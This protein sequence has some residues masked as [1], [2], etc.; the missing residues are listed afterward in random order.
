MGGRISSLMPVIFL[1]LKKQMGLVNQISPAP[2]CE[3]SDLKK[4]AKN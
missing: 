4:K 2:F 3:Q 1:F